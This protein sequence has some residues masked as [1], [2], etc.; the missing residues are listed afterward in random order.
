MAIE[1][2]SSG[3]ASNINSCLE[4]AS[5]NGMKTLMISARN[6]KET[7]ITSTLFNWGS[8]YHTEV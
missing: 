4:L 6:L 7:S 3:T 5:N 2:S 1:I 8:Y